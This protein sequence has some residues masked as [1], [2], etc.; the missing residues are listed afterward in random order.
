VP[1]RARFVKPE[2]ATPSPLPVRCPQSRPSSLLKRK[3]R[4]AA[5]GAAGS[6]KTWAARSWAARCRRA[7]LSGRADRRLR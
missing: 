6:E 4:A 5:G 3:V 1:Q 7:S 2:P